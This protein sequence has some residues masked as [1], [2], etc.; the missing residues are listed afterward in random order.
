MLSVKQ[1]RDELMGRQDRLSHWC[2]PRSKMFVDTNDGKTFDS[3]ALL[4]SWVVENYSPAAQSKFLA[5]ADFVLVGFAHAYGHTVVTL[6][7]AASG[8][9]VK[10]PNAC[11]A[12][13][14]A[15]VSPFEMLAAEK[16]SFHL[17]S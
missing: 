10:I 14:V 2:K 11:K 3:L 1:V 9:E 15:K 6:E 4:T 13:N 7:A 17:T 12:M 16:V 8:I 5:A